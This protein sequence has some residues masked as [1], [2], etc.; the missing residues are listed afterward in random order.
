MYQGGLIFASY[1]ASICNAYIKCRSKGKNKGNLSEFFL[2]RPRANEIAC[3][4]PLSSPYT[5]I[6]TSLVYIG[7]K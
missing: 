7:Q 6:L 1:L 2:N 5:P 4:I 3:E